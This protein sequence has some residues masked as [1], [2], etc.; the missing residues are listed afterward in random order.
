[1]KRFVN[2]VRNLSDPPSFWR[3][4]YRRKQAGH[5]RD[6]LRVPLRGGLTA[7]VP[8]A[9][10]GSFD[11]VFLREVYGAGLRALR[12]PAPVVIDIGANAGLFSL[13]VFARHPHARVLAF[14]PL[15]RHLAM[16]ERQIASN[17]GLGITV[18]ARA[19]FGEKKT[20]EIRFDSRREFSTD[21]SLFPV[22]GADA[23]VTVEATTL[24]DLYDRYAVVRC[25]LLKLDC[26]GAEFDIL[27]KCP[28]RVFAVTD[29]IVFEVH[30]RLA[31]HGST[32]DLV[33]FLRGKGYRVTSRKNG[34]NGMVTCT[35]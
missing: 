7:I 11:E 32:E 2:S 26:E 4:Y 16:L 29:T 31:G 14:E 17:P 18:D 20:V 15:P 24:A 19:V 23:S 1:M 13:R 6:E 12:G 34:N 3:Q 21:A 25:H 10:M 28:D 27:Y 9:L 8:G 22:K 35:R 5:E 33:G 30:E